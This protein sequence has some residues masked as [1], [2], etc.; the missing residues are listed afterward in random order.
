MK[1]AERAQP[2]ATKVIKKGLAFSG[3][4][5]FVF[6]YGWLKKAADAILVRP[7]TFTN[8]GAMVIL[9]VGKNMVRSIRHWA[10]ATRILEEKPHTRGAELRLTNSGKC[11]LG[12]V[13]LTRT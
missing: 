11:C 9:G 3:H 13:E 4:E 2:A 1:A 8:D 10:I 6:R 7:D 5:T 12:P